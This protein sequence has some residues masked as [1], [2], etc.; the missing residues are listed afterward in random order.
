MIHQCL[1]SS[2]PPSHLW[3]RSV[4][5]CDPGCPSFLPSREP[6]SCFSE[7]HLCRFSVTSSPKPHTHNFS[8]L[9]PALILAAATAANQDTVIFSSTL[10]FTRL[11]PSTH[12]GAETGLTFVHVDV[13]SADVALP[14]WNLSGFWSFMEFFSKRIFA[15][16]D[17]K[18]YVVTSN[19]SNTKDDFLQAWQKRKHTHFQLKAFCIFEC[20]KNFELSASIYRGFGK[21]DR[22]LEISKS[23]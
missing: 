8:C 18:Y 14:L 15:H 17:V 21:F 19:N 10:T 2:L 20:N 1:A 11:W 9:C 3:N 13:S 16:R 7:P 22:F 5:L 4:L 12:I 23:T 6:L